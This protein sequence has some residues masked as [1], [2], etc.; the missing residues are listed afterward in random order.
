MGDSFDGGALASI[1][2]ELFPSVWCCDDEFETF[3]GTHD[4]VPTYD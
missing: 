4:T 2:R 3:Y 1:W